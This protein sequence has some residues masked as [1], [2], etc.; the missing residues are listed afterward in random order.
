MITC[1]EAVCKAPRLLPGNKE[2]YVSAVGALQR[3][4]TATT[5]HVDE[6]SSLDVHYTPNQPALVCGGEDGRQW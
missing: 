5:L 1:T 4:H 6:R 3:Q 2:A